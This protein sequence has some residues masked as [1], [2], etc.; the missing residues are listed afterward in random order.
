MKFYDNK[1]KGFGLKKNRKKVPVAY[2]IIL[3]VL[4]A[5]LLMLVAFLPLELKQKTAVFFF[6][7]PVLT[8]GCVYGYNM[9]M[10][11]RK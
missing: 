7:L 5:G 4:I 11:K 10:N 3:V 8:L 6:G 1:R 2:W 9:I